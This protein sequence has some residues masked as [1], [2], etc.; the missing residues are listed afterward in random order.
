[1][2]NDKKKVHSLDIESKYNTEQEVGDDLRACDLKL[3]FVWE[4]I[5]TKGN[6]F[7]SKLLHQEHFLTVLPCSKNLR[8]LRR[9]SY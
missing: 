3:E 1:M 9:S 6:D 7:F 8:E 2:K 4:K 5:K